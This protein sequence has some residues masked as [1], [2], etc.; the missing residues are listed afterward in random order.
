MR[1]QGANSK[2]ALIEYYTYDKADTSV[3]SLKLVDTDTKVLDCELPLFGAFYEKDDYY[4]LLTG[5]NNPTKSPDVEIYRVTKYD[6]DWN[7]IGEMGLKNCNTTKPFA[8][9]TAHMAAS[10]KYLV[11]RTCHNMYNGHQANVMIQLDIDTMTITDSF[12]GVGGAGYVSHSF[13]HFIKIDEND[14]IIAAD[15]GDTYPR[16]V[17]LTKYN[18]TVSSG[19]FNTSS[20]R[21]TVFTIGSS[22]VYTGTSVGGFEISDSSYLVAGNSCMRDDNTNTGKSPRDI[23]VS[24][25]KKDNTGVNVTWLTNYTEANDSASTP[26]LVE[27]DKDNYVVLWQSG[28][29]VC[30]KSITGDGKLATPSAISA[31]PSAVDAIDAKLVEESTT[32]TDGTIC[33]MEGNLS[34]VTPIVVNDE[35]VWYTWNEKNITFYGINTKNLFE[36][37]KK[38]ITN[39][40][41]VYPPSAISSQPPED[42]SNDDIDEYSPSNI[43]LGGGTSLDYTSGDSSASA[44]PSTVPSTA[45][46]TMPS[47]MPSAVPSN[48]ST[49]V[50]AGSSAPSSGSPDAIATTVPTATE[51]PAA[52]Q[53]PASFDTNQKPSLKTA[54]AKG[55]KSV[56][57]NWDKVDGADGYIISQYNKKNNKYKGIKTISNP[58]K[59]TCSIKMSYATSYSFKIRAFKTQ[60]D[61]SKT[62]GKYSS[63]IKVTTAPAKVNN[64]TVKRAGNSK[65]S[66]SWKKVQRANGYQIFSS[67]KKNG[68]YSLV[69]TLKKGSTLSTMVKQ[70]GKKTCYYKVRAYVTNADKKRVYGNFGKS[71]TLK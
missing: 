53:E 9:G 52:S 70:N 63:I 4:F 8:F 19:K 27:V 13:Q 56:K 43:I 48:T 64:L 3:Q 26:H 14:H 45:P 61:G 69:K 66:L 47:A 25:D 58:E 60:E 59:T 6:K 7:R 32:A 62:Y 51:T 35:I 2:G 71:L 44:I 57:F 1:V 54:V 12:T 21:K 46:S 55:S 5:Q 31:T 38:D 67:N 37:Y 29:K 28:N 34:D 41:V 65:V 10:G 24:A 17:I 49:S 68:K 22:G 16:G 20:T 15:H 50:P 23:F 42:D 33:E 36:N 18:S 39:E 30:Y 40:G 11:V